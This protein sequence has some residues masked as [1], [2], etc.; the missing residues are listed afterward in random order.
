MTCLA[1]CQWVIE[2][3]SRAE[4]YAASVIGTNYSTMIDFRQYCCNDDK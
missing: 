4:N 1:F 2:T 3:L